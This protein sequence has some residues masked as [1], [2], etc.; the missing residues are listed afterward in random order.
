ME[1]IDIYRAAH[2]ILKLYKE[3]AVAEAL[4]GLVRLKVHF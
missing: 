3:H 2:L 1:K 4:K